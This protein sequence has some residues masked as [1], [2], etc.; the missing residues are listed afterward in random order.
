M[1]KDFVSLHLHSNLHFEDQVK[2]ARLMSHSIFL[3]CNIITTCDLKNKHEVLIK[4][5][6]HQMDRGF[7][8][9]TLRCENT[10]TAY[11]STSPVLAGTVKHVITRNMNLFLI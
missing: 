9:S 3:N 5:C 8:I 10:N 7:C 1:V 6:I 2:I 11:C 4:L